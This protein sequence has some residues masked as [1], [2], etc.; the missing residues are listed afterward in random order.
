MKVGDGE[1]IAREVGEGCSISRKQ[2]DI[3]MNGGSY[4][5]IEEDPFGK[6]ASP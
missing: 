5:G 4:D 6:L 2:M 1:A 3:F